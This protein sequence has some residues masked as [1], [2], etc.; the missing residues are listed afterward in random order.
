LAG[1]AQRAGIV[2]LATA[3]VTNT[4]IAVMVKGRSADRDPL[5]DP[6][7][8]P[9]CP[10]RGWYSSTSA[11]PR[12]LD[13]VDLEV[14]RDPG[15]VLA[16]PELGLDPV[17]RCSRQS[18]PSQSVALGLLGLQCFRGMNRTLLPRGDVPIAQR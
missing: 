18:R 3:G 13:S 1:L 2:L 6:D 17:S 16:V 9:S 15:K 10:P 4:A 5:A 12:G 8:H 11:P 7:L 14:V